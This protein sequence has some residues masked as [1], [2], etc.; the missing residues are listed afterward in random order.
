MRKPNNMRR[1]QM[2]HRSFSPLA[3]SSLAAALLVLGFAAPAVADSFGN[4]ELTG[5]KASYHIT[6]V[7]P[8]QLTV[9]VSLPAP[10]WVNGNT[11]DTIKG[12][13]EYCMAAVMAYRLGLP[14][15]AI[16]NVAWAQLIGGN[17][18]NYDLALDQ[19]SITEPRKKVV[20]FSV[21]YFNSDI[22][23]LVK[24][25]TKV[26]SESVK[27]MRI[28]VHQGTTGADFVAKVLKPHKEVK[29]YANVPGMM[30]ALA[31]GQID[32]GANDTAYMLGYASKSNGKF[33]VVG[34]Y[35]TGETYG[36]VYPKGS[37]NE[38]TFDKIIKAMKDDGTLEKF[39]K[40]YLAEAWG[41]DPT[42]IPYFK[43]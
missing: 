29:V 33:V 25:G 7:V 4:C 21:P 2:S 22:G 41:A 20:D 26:D 6:P 16:V 36:A 17:T 42:K 35:H 12:G 34:Q 3:K 28:G 13:F 1:E 8:G 31:A 11:P 27:D 30:A 40:K 39:E 14:K 9:E 18:K 5:Q 43:P 15:L 19:A 38:A 37:P 10:G 32:A 24:A 23:I